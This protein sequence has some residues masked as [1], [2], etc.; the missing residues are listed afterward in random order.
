MYF[1]IG[2]I[3]AQQLNLDTIIERSARAVEEVLPQGTKVAVLNFA[4]TSETFSDHVIDELTGK[5]VNGRKI[6]IVDRRNLALITNEMNLQLS[7]DVSDESAQAIGRMLGAQSIISGNLTNMGTFYRFRVRVINVETAAIQTQV[8]LDLRNDEQV[9]FLLGGSQANLPPAT[10]GGTTSIGNLI[11]GT[12][13]PG[14]NLTEKLAWLQRSADSHN[15]YI[16]VVNANENITPHVFQYEGAI[17]ITIVLRGDNV[18]RTVRLRSHGTM[19]TVKP[20]VTFI[21][22]N[23]ITLHGHSGN[24]NPNPRANPLDHATLVWVDGGKFIMNNGST[25]TGN[26]AGGVFIHSSRSVFEMT[27]GTISNNKHHGVN[28][29][30]GAT[31]IM[32]GGNITGNSTAIENHAGAGVLVRGTFTM[33]GGTISSNTSNHHQIGGGGVHIINGTFNMRGGIISNNISR[34]NGGGV[35]ISSSGTFNKTGGIITGYSSDQSNGNAVMDETGNIIARRGHAVFI[36][37]TRR[38]ETTAGTG[39]NLNNNTAGG[40]D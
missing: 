28:M 20:N 9:A 14:G 15:T 34:A 10:T 26:E 17:N 5:L 29:H 23:N 36:S 6:T 24:I 31:F 7:G 27:G 25:I 21:L 32:S 35:F 38:K 16:V 11:E 18:N 33:T 2:G 37:T 13:V 22:D 8:S 39:V 1:V 30:D 40:W 3:Y 19:F 12:I 4:S